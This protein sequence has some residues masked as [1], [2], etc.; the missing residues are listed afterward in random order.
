MLYYVFLLLLLLLLLI[1]IIIIII[2]IKIF[3]IIIVIGYLCLFRVPASQEKIY[4]SCWCLR[5]T[6]CLSLSIQLL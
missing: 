4:I 6:T 1:I 2:I 3:I 5:V